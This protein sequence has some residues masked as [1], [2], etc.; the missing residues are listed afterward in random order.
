MQIGRDVCVKRH[1]TFISHQLP[2]VSS[3]LAYSG[4]RLT[5]QLSSKTMGAPSSSTSS[6]SPSV[7]VRALNLAANWANMPRCIRERSALSAER[8]YPFLKADLGDPNSHKG[9]F[10][11][12]RNECFPHPALSL[13]II[14]ACDLIAFMHPLA[15]REAVAR[16]RGI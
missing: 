16:R 12:Y 8:R 1:Y 4:L 10:C 9:P 3:Q 2:A 14:L 6:P 7:P 11:T 15:A 13:C 5:M